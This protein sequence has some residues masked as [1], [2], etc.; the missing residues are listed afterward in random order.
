MKES[1]LYKKLKNNQ[2]QCRGCPHYCLL[3]EGEL[4]KCGVRKNINGKLYLLNYEKVVALNVDPI[5]KKPLF[6]FL[7][8]STSLSL[9]SAG[10]NFSCLYCQNYDVSQDFRQKPGIPGRNISAEEVVLL[11]L[12]K[13]T[14]SI[15]YTYTEPTVFL[16]YALEIM[17]LAHENELKNVWVTNGF[18]STESLKLLLPYLDAAN[19]DLKGFDDGFYPKGCG[20]RLEPVLKTLRAM[21]KANVRLEITTLVVPTLNDKLETFRK[22]ASFIKNELGEKVPWH[23]TRFSGAL[24]WK[25]DYLPDTPVQTL[26]DAYQIAKK[27]GLKYV[28]SGNVYGLNL[29]NTYCPQCDALAIERSGYRVKRFDRNGRC[30]QCG[31]DLDIFE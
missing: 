4:G 31:A 11:A 22:I 6:H 3:K 25:L 7:P 8:G 24:S 10:C 16:E 21:K 15:S 2:V 20:G 26:K 23:I 19:V 1:R 17:K 27:Q 30:R 5:E 9:A 12:E 28:Y 18:L 14:P 29:E 13:K